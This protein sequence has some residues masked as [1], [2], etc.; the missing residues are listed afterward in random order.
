MTEVPELDDVAARALTSIIL[1]RTADTVN[2]QGAKS[3]EALVLFHGESGLALD[4]CAA[5]L[6]ATSWLAGAGGIEAGAVFAAAVMYDPSDDDD[7]G[8][9]S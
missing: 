2:D 5:I 3:A 1:E 4:V 7:G 9:G 6:M 8:T